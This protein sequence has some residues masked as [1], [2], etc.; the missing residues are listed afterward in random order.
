M[1]FAEI[2][3][4]VDILEPVYKASY[5]LSMKYP[6]PAILIL[7]SSILTIFAIAQLINEVL[8]AIYNFASNLF[9]KQSNPY[10][11]RYVPYTQPNGRMANEKN[12][13]SWTMWTVLVV[14]GYIFLPTARC[15]V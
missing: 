12:V 6:L 15:I 10:E 9:R 4:L 8:N 7:I 3:D 2:L 13:Q 1:N 14:L 11:R 5:N